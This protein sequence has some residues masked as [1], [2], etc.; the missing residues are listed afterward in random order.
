MHTARCP[1][2]LLA[3]LLLLAGA[4]SA[5]ALPIKNGNFAAPKAAKHGERVQPPGFQLQ[6]KVKRVTRF[7]AAPPHDAALALGNGAVL[8]Y[9]VL[10]P[11]PAAPKKLDPAGWYAVASVEVLGRVTPAGATLE[12]TASLSGAAKA[13]AKASLTPSRRASRGGKTIARGPPA[14]RLWL[15]I[16]AKL[17]ASH[18]G[19]TLTIRLAVSGKGRVVIDDFHFDLFHREPGRALVGKPNGKNGPDLLASGML[20]FLALTEHMGTAFSLLEVR[21]GGPAEKAG[22]QRSDLVVAVEGTPLVASSLA[23]GLPWFERSHEAT[24]GRAIERALANSQ[25]HVRLTVLRANAKGKTV[26]KDLKVKLPTTT[27]FADS[28][29][30]DDPL[31]A[32]MRADTIRW[33]VDNQKPNGS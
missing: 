19:E 18:A 22:L 12:A 21:K 17:L 4:G 16:P 25:K 9:E 28:F 15:R 6:G 30:F 29:P 8:L 27:G 20:G 7:H 32:E 1:A 3:F 31:A 33:I 13:L 10:L 2:I 23:P 14:E 24:L 26:R 11:Q 5:Q